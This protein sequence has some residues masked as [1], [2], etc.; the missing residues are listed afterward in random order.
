MSTNP[1]KPTA[2]TSANFEKLKVKLR[3]MFE[4]D[5]ADLDFGV[6]RIGARVLGFFLW[7]GRSTYRT[8]VHDPRRIETWI[9][10]AG[11]KKRYE[12]RTFIWLT[13]VYVRD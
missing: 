1:A 13:Q 2:P 6:Y 7:L 9:T 11:L 4:P 8:Y 5:K 3:E 10:A 12:N